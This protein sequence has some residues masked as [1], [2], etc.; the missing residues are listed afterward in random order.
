MNSSFLDSLSSLLYMP[1]MGQSDFT[2]PARLGRSH[3]QD[4]NPNSVLNSIDL[5]S[6][7]PVA[8]S[9]T[10]P[11]RRPNGG[12]QPNGGTQMCV[13]AFTRSMCAAS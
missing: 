12:I 6:R 7:F 5:S 2:T 3:H 8:R 4:G 13:D 10:S 11:A 9:R 1:E